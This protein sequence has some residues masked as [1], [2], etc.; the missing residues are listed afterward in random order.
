[1]AIIKK[2]PQQIEKIRIS[3]QYLNE[4]MHILYQHCTIGATGKD[5]ENIMKAYLMK[6]HLRSAF[7]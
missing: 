7:K 5:I 4:L 1:M 6:H 2:N 3:G